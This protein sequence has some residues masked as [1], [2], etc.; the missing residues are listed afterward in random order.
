MTA[1]GGFA[2][3]R[4]A[5]CQARGSLLALAVLLLAPVAAAQTSVDRAY[6]SVTV[7]PGASLGQGVG[8][9]TQ[10]RQLDVFLSLPPL[11]LDGT[12]LILAPT[13]GY[14]RRAL[15]LE[16][17]RLREEDAS[18]Y[19]LHSVQLGLSLIRPLPPRWLL[20][21][22]VS[23]AARSDFRGGLQPGEDLAWTALALASYSLDA[24]R[25]VKLS[26]GLV[27]V[28]PYDLLPVI[29]LVGLVYRKG[30]YIAEVGFPR[31]HLLRKL[32]EGLEVGVT[33][34]F[35]RQTFHASLPQARDV[36]G[37]HHVRETT[38]RVA[39]ALNVRLAGALWVNTAAGLIAANDFT[40][41]DARRARID[42]VDL[43]VGM[44][45]FARVDLSWR[46]APRA[47]SRP[48]ATPRR[49]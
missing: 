12:R 33:A 41:L 29:P 24:E 40:L 30:S 36:L 9:L 18:G 14:G 23:A 46:P 42:T 31:V 37:A 16:A 8:W 6:V 48:E 32:G 45:P 44:S 47:P 10:R 5:R 7:A 22:G 34:S 3:G 20:I 1:S 13:V 26:F 39:H 43:G 27:A 38:L 2:R 15:S 11:F 28:Y 19:H 25:T 35:E 17:S 4:R 49:P 21:A